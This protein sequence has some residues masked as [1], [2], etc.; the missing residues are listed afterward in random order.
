MKT[1]KLPKIDW[2]KNEEQN[3]G[4]TKYEWGLVE[5]EKIPDKIRIIESYTVIWDNK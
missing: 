1:V 3:V 5:D 2:N 4:H